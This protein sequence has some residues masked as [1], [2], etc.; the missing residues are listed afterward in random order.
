MGHG[1]AIIWG[2]DAKATFINSIIS[3]EIGLNF[4]LR[5]H[6]LLSRLRFLNC[7]VGTADNLEETI[8]SQ[9]DLNTIE[10]YGS[11]ISSD[12]GFYAWTEDNPYS[13]GQYSPCIDAGTTDFN[14]FTMPDW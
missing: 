12:P 4:Y 2:E 14:L 11:N 6:P 1:A 10:W 8:Y 3:N 9:G 7:L 13:L 5:Y